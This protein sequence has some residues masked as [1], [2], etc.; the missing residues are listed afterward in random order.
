[1]PPHA[2]QYIILARQDGECIVVG[3]EMAR[4]ISRV[5]YVVQHCYK[6]ASEYKDIALSTRRALRRLRYWGTLARVTWSDT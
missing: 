6:L 1:M 2:L 5:P 3:L 4:P